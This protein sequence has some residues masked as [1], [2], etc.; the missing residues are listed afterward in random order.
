MGPRS[1]CTAHPGQ[2]ISTSPAGS[3]LEDV[4]Y[5]T[6]GARL[7][8]S[9]EAA[10]ANANQSDLPTSHAVQRGEDGVELSIALSCGINRDA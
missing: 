7:A 5:V 3:P 8:H 6:W 4:G 10:N 2:A 1:C 9:Q